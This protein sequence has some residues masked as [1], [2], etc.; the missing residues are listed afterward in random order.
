MNDQLFEN[1]LYFE[2]SEKNTS[3]AR[4]ELKR[5]SACERVKYALMCNISKLKMN[6]SEICN[7]IFDGK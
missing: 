6:K 3:L 2:N 4:Q 5:L 7:K 1:T